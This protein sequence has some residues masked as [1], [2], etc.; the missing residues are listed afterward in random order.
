VKTAAGARIGAQ[1][2][3]LDDP[4]DAGGDGSAEQRLRPGGV[5]GLE[6]LPAALSNDPGGVDDRVDAVQRRGQV[7]LRRRLRQIEVEPGLGLV[8]GRG[9]ASAGDHQAMAPAQQGLAQ[10]TSDEAARADEEE[11]HGSGNSPCLGQVQ[12]SFPRRIQG[13]R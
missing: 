6:A 4:R 3:D 11:F 5:Q 9:F 12:A 8:L 7:V 13:P 2:G 10:A 1:R